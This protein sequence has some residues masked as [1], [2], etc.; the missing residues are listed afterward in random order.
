[1]KT[2]L[3]EWTNMPEFIQEKDAPYKKLTV[4]FATAEA[5]QDFAEKIGQKLTEK[6]KSIW[7]P[8]LVRGIHSGKEYVDA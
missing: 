6:T 1:M 5:Y 8:Q 7:H 4:R 2:P 3:E